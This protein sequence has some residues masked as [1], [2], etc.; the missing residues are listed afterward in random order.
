MGK[1]SIFG[2]SHT[3]NILVLCLAYVDLLRWGIRFIC[4]EGKKKKKMNCSSHNIEPF[5]LK[6]TMFVPTADLANT[7]MNRKAASQLLVFI[8]RWSLILWARTPHVLSCPQAEKKTRVCVGESHS[9]IIIP[10]LLDLHSNWKDNKTIFITS[11]I[12]IL[13]QRQKLEYVHLFCTF[14][15]TVQSASSV[16]QCYY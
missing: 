5:S 14:V 4:A 15:F 10:L 2:K 13:A 9:V 6:G 11:Y 12:C 8:R 3:K 7:A 1:K 16:K